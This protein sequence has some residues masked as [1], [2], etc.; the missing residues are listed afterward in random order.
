MV[1]NRCPVRVRREG[2]RN[3]T[4]ERALERGFRGKAL[5]DGG[6]RERLEG[7]AGKE[8]SFSLKIYTA[9]G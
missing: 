7:K 1:E 4:S 3:V 9:R 2:E 6:S 8:G 5:K